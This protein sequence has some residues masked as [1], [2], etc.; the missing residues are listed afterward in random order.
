[1]SFLLALPTMTSGAPVPKVGSSLEATIVA[2]L[3][4]HV[5]ALPAADV[6]VIGNSASKAAAVKSKSLV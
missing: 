3:P 6:P 5:G 4:K 1:M 2:G